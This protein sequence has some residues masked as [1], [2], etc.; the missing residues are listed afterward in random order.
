MSESSSASQ[1][2]TYFA[3]AFCLLYPQDREK[4]KKEH[5]FLVI[6]CCVDKKKLKLKKYKENGGI[7]VNYIKYNYILIFIFNFFVKINFKKSY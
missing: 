7:L 3:L 4:K 1:G 6:I 5:D 2:T